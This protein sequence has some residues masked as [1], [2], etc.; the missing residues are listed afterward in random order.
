MKAL[1]LKQA[2]Q[3]IAMMALLSACGDSYVAPE[4][5]PPPGGWPIGEGLEV[6]ERVSFEATAV[7]SQLAKTMVVTNRSETP[8]RLFDIHLDAQTSLPDELQTGSPWRAA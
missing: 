1:C 4:P 7:G 6:T 2:L 8:L 3:L 5:T